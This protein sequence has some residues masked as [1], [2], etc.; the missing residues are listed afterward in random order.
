MLGGNMITLKTLEVYLEKCKDALKQVT[1]ARSEDFEKIRLLEN[2]RKELHEQRLVVEG[3]IAVLEDLLTIKD[4]HHVELPFA[5]DDNIEE[6]HEKRLEGHMGM[7]SEEVKRFREDKAYKRESMSM[8]ER[9]NEL[10]QEKEEEHV[11]EIA[12]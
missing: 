12:S 9:I 3:Q 4:S 11:S 5:G 8:V 7:S 1:D 6:L 2:H 10:K